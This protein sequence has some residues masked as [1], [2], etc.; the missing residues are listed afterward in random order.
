MKA[1]K[2][3]T[4]VAS[5]Y[6]PTVNNKYLWPWRISWPVCNYSVLR[7]KKKNNNITKEEIKR[8]RELFNLLTILFFFSRRCLQ[9]ARH[10]Y[11][12]KH[13]KQVV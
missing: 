5:A 11:G 12:R 8:K 2:S 4:W 13:C 1:G 9:S 7:G 10:W 6:V 3:R